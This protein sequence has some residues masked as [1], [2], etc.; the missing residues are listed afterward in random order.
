MQIDKDLNDPASASRL[1]HFEDCRSAIDQL[2]TS[3]LQSRGACAFDE[4]LD[5]IIRFNNLSVYNA[6]LVRIQRPGAGAV[7]TRRK[8][9][10]VGREIRPDAVPIVILQPFGPVSFLFDQADTFGKPLPAENENPLF[11]S[12]RLSQDIYDQTCKA[13]E[14]YWITV[15]ET[16]KYGVLLAGTASGFELMPGTAINQDAKSRR[17]RRNFTVRLNAKHGLTTRFATLAH[18]LGH[19]YCG[20]VGADSAGRWPNRFNLNTAEMELEAEAVAWLVCQRNGVTTKSREYLADL[21]ERA[22]LEKVSMFAVF[23]AANR[24]ESRT[25]P[26]KL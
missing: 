9:Q 6:M 16:D 23:E 7:A 1:A 8:W 4:F 15:E 2:F 11:A 25:P 3:A 13:A 24:V 18:E 21:I 14:K 12:G 5:F 26:Q 22:N 19:I 17:S 10:R 20:H